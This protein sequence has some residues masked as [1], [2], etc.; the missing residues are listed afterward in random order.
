VN[1]AIGSGLAAGA[2]TAKAVRAGDFSAAALASYRTSMQANFVLSDHKR[3][4]DAPKLVLNERLHAQYTS[5][6]CDMA[7]AIFTVVNPEPK[8]RMTAL[9]RR[10]VKDHGVRWRDLAK[11]AA[12]GGRIFR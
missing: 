3:M 9:L 7:E 1:F 8:P 4:K 10:T 5:L 11:D 12:L 2:A 6:I